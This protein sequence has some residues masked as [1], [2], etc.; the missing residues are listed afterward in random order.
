[1]SEA[2]Q[3]PLRL[4]GMALR[5]GLM[6]HGPTHWSAAVRLDDGTIKVA[7]GRNRA[8]PSV[9]GTPILRGA[10]RL[11]ATMA[12]LPKMRRVLP[13]A[14]L[15]FESPAMV[16]TAL[17]GAAVASGARR[18]RLS[19]TTTEALTQLLALLPA[20]ATLRS[21]AVARYHGAEHKTI[22]GYEGEAPALD[23]A[24]E[25]ERCGSHLVLPMLATSLVGN[26]LA[27]RLRS[28]RGAQATRLGTSVAAAGVAVE[29]FGWMTRNRTHRIAGLLRAPGTML[30][31]RIGT[32]E[33]TADELAVAAA[34][35]AELLGLE[36]GGART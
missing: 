9:G 20:M 28:A 13:E 17:A 16:V 10:V 35:L 2:R 1:M 24:K 15:A 21:G 22:A 5:N 8:V 31:R 18:S 14:R 27:G 4:G 11:A 23:A 30:Q 26:L 7:S 6:L 34:A 3:E 12:T 32:E 29:V 19:P 33:P 36:S 25:H